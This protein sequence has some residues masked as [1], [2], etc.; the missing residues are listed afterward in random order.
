MADKVT[1]QIDGDASGLAKA[2]TQGGQAMDQATDAA[3]TLQNNVQALKEV[4]SRLSANMAETSRQLSA[5]S[6]A[7]TEAT[8][9]ASAHAEA[10]RKD[11]EAQEKTEGSFKKVAGAFKDLGG[12]SLSMG[13]EIRDGTNPLLA[14]VEQAPAVVGALAE[15]GPV[16]VA[17]S[18]G[19]TAL[20]TAAY[21][22]IGDFVELKQLSKDISGHLTAVGLGATGSAEQVEAW[23]NSL[24]EDFGL[25]QKDAAAVV[26]AIR[27]IGVASVEEKDKLQ[28]Y[29]GM[30]ASLAPALGGADKVAQALAG[31]YKGGADAILEL[32]KALNFLT[33]SDQQ[34][35]RAA[36]QNNDL[37]AERAILMHALSQRYDPLVQ[38]EHDLA[39]AIRKREALGRGFF[40]EDNGWS[41]LSQERHQADQ[42]VEVARNRVDSLKKTP[43][44][45]QKAKEADGRAAEAERARAAEVARIA[46]E[47]K[48]QA[49]AAARA[50]QAQE[51]A[52][53]TERRRR[54]REAL[55]DQLAN[56][57]DGVAATREGSVEREA[58]L[59][60]EL[61]FVKANYGARSAE[62]R[63]VEKE[64]TAAR[65]ATLDEETADL[66]KQLQ[67]SLRNMDDHNNILAKLSAKE[68]ERYGKGSDALRKAQETDLAT[69]RKYLDDKAKEDIDQS[70]EDWQR[71][72]KDQEQKRQLQNMS[73]AE[74]ATAKRAEVKAQN[75]ATVA[76]LEGY[77]QQALAAAAASGEEASVAKDYDEKIAKIRRAAEQQDRDIT[78]QLEHDKQKE[79]QQT[80]SGITKSMGTM[81][82][83][84][85]T[86]T[87]TVRQAVSDMAKS[88]L[89]ELVGM[90]EKQANAWIMSNLIRQDS[91]QDTAT[92]AM[93]QSVE[94]ATA[95]IKD[96]AATGAA[97]AYASASAGP[98][99]WVA[100][101]ISA[102]VQL[103]ISGLTSSLSSAAGG[104]GRVP[105]DGML[106]ELHK[107]EMVLPASIASPLRS[108]LAA[109]TLPNLAVPAYAAAN[110]NLPGRGVAN[111]NAVSGT[112]GGA[113]VTFTVQAMDSRDVAS[114]F[115]RHGD[116]LVSALR[117]QKR[118]FS[119]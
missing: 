83:G 116:K 80:V 34:A 107:D 94:T 65:K 88:A 56:I 64:I 95:Q 39:E 7:L 100:P 103:A 118:N 29:T 20:G 113:N 23:I 91:D 45:D 28:G 21:V 2:A 44:P 35:L 14:I 85:V 79:Y 102:A 114:F 105:A 31:A 74:V 36:K 5:A 9:Q 55:G 109:Q 108:A 43:G 22:V 30:L 10:S 81:V 106:T 86:G 87:K 59:A 75:D 37:L 13:K 99:W 26:D 17:V 4:A 38:A 19:L 58:A 70:N 97:N 117:G 25:S 24:H 76:I 42:D 119:F 46:A 104:W 18:L 12:A 89:S 11:A 50:R 49:D 68:Q 71:Y 8:A 90:A 67:D 1:V 6:S 60:G 48:A 62:A 33:V 66:R 110:L 61:D 98:A 41:G 57:R 73:L 47:E 101:A 115:N 77:R 112:G 40:E 69:V 32:D 72:A 63:R 111:T 52:A 82:Q 53:T 84:L 27:S 54:A 51:E 16:G 92:K 78:H 96:A 93:A 3:V 15:F